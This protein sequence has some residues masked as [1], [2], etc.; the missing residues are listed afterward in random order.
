MTRA[1]AKQTEYIQKLGY[2]GP[3]TDLNA[4]QASTLIERI[5]LRLDDARARIRASV[6]VIEL[7]ERYTPLRKEGTGEYSGPCPKCAGN[8]RFHCKEDFWF[9][10]QCYPLGNGLP[11]DAVAFL[12]WR[13]NMTEAE[14]VTALAGGGIST[15]GE[16][17]TQAQALAR[18]PKQSAN[19][20]DEPKQRGKMLAS[21]DMLAAGQTV[22]AKAGLAYLESRGI[23]KTAINVFKLG[24]CAV[25]LPNTWDDKKQIHV[26]PQQLALALPWFNHDGVLMCVKYRYF[27]AHTYTDLDGE[28]RTEGKNSRGSS[29]GQAFGWQ[30]LQG[31][32]VCPVL[33]IT[34]GEVN[35]LSIWQVGGGLVDVLST[36]SESTTKVLPANIVELAKQYKHRIVWADKG[37]IADAAALSIGAASMRSPNGQDANDLL[38]AGKLERMIKAMLDKLGVQPTPAQEAAPLVKLEK[39]IKYDELSTVP[40]PPLPR[41]LWRSEI[42]DFTEAWHAWQALRKDYCAVMGHHETGYYIDDSV[43]EDLRV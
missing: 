33:I 15:L 40:R 1:T 32:N 17:Q 43:K 20:W 11:H 6:N 26:Y 8:D 10:R 2:T 18:K 4:T 35:A 36:G 29:T 7:C 16:I 42:R 19:E 24:A 12:I 41:E 30:A 25:G 21:H 31:P 39:V 27:Q 5:K 14:A 3:L 37:M 9:C 23:D 34:E 28:E 22:A 13:E 38:R